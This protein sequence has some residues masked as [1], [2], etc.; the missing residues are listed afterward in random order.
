MTVPGLDDAVSGYIFGEKKAT[1][2]A[3]SLWRHVVKKGDTV[4]DATCGNG[5][6]TLAMVKLVKDELGK[7][8]VYGLDLQEDAI[9]STSHLL[10]L[11]LNPVE[12][13][14]V[15]LFSIC[16]SRM[17]EVLPENSCVRL[18]AFNL[19]Y[20]PGG[21]KTI[22][23]QPDT[24]LRALEAAKEILVSGGAISVAAYVGH[25]GGRE[26]YEIV[27]GFASKLQPESW[28]CSQIQML[29]KP[30]APILLF[31]FKR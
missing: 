28:S 13:K 10:D 16:H 7:G 1:E 27:Q 17:A 22:I 6:D 15:K 4:V 25:P 26:E 21:D 2:V 11:S 14:S 30:S 18:V 20:L 31:L 24:T 29:N 3:H 12:R 23:T 5:N 9:K 8:C 19:G